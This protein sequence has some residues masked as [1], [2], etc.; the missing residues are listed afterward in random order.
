MDSF[1]YT[2]HS[3]FIVGAID[4]N[5]ETIFRGI[6]F[7]HT[8]TRKVC[9]LNDS[10]MIVGIGN[11]FKI[12][13]VYKFLKKSSTLGHLT[14]YDETMDAIR[15]V[16]NSSKE[17]FDK[18]FQESRDM[19]DEA[20]RKR[21]GEEIPAE[22]LR[23]IFADKPSH[24]A[25]LEDTLTGMYYQQTTLTQFHLLGWDE[26]LNRTRAT[27]LIILGHKVHASEMPLESGLIYFQSA[28]ATMDINFVKSLDQLA[29]LK[30]SPISSTNTMHSPDDVGELIDS[31]KEILTE[32]I[33][34][35]SPYTRAPSVVFYELS[36]RTDFKFRE[37]EVDLK[38]VIFNRTPT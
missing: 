9:K 10:C 31:T 8:S 6:A 32:T 24:L 12:W 26:K 22:E 27:A 38:D 17:D 30:L 5:Y 16:F 1:A 29:A 21:G 18:I 20:Q 36:A 13:D 35:L 4:T 23:R 34:G 7:Q 14:S 37:P 33:T 19:L 2:A 3:K 15:D 11:E 25:V 28:S